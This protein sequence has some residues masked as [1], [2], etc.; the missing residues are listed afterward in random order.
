MFCTQCGRE[1]IEGD[2]F[3]PSCGKPTD[4]S[5]PRPSPSRR[6]ARDMSDKKIAGVCSGFARYLAVDVTLVRIVW[7]LIVL[8]AGT[9]VLAYII[10]WI[11]MPADYSTVDM[12]G[13]DIQPT[14]S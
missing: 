3:C 13:K 9:G 6:L 12:G 1:M 7:I 2:K 14:A 8:A 5:V 10:A 11:V 4:P